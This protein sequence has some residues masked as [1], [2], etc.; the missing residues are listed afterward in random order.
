M[1]RIFGSGN[2]SENDPFLYID[3]IKQGLKLKFV[4]NYIRKV[5]VFIHRSNKTRI[6]TSHS[7]SDYIY[8]HL[9]LYIDPIKQ[10][11]KPTVFIHI[12][13]WNLFL[14]IDP[15]KQ[16]LKL[17]NSYWA[18]RVLSGFLYIDPIK[19][20]LKPVDIVI[21]LVIKSCVF[22]HRSNKTRIETPVLQASKLQY[23]QFLYIDPI[24][25]GLKLFRLRNLQ[26][27][28]TGFYT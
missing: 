20:G 6:E 21:G 5:F 3:P 18:R 28:P 1:K 2:T 27:F 8:R 15:I 23:K 16:G 17:A 25:Q 22:I 7:D 13:S 14:Y 19:Q 24:K 11:L 4:Y 26:I 12:W 9:F 10:G